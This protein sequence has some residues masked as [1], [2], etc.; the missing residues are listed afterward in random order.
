MKNQFLKKVETMKKSNLLRVPNKKSL[1]MIFLG[2]IIIISSNLLLIHLLPNE[3]FHIIPDPFITYSFLTSN[4]LLVIGV[5][6]LM[7]VC[8]L[9]DVIAIF[10]LIDFFR[11]SN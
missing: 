2:T 6:I 4:P 9:L 3:F 11:P 10:D 8:I 1:L 7:V 5:N